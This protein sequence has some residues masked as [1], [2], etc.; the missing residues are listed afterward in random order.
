MK[1]LKRMITV[2]FILTIISSCT[3]FLAQVTKRSDSDFKYDPF[4]HENTDYDVL[5]FG[6]SHVINAIFPMQLW[7]DYGITSYNFGGHANSLAASYWAMVNA[8]QYHKPKIAV[9][10]VLGA[11]QES[12]EMDI[13]YAHLSFDAFPLTNTKLKA[14]KDI[15]PNDSK[16][17]LELIFPYSIYHNKW[18][19]ITA[20]AVKSVVA[21]RD[22]TKEKGAESRI[23]LAIPQEMNLIPKSDMAS[24]SSVGQKYIEMF[25]DYCRTNDIE[26][27]IIN[28]PYPTNEYHQKWSNSVYKLS[29]QSGFSYLNMQYEN[30]VDFDI[31]CHDPS[32]HLNPSGARKITDYLGKYLTA[33][34]NLEDHRLDDLYQSWNEAYQKE[35]RPFL[36][37]K[38]Q[39]QKSFK[40][41]LMLLNNE[42]FSA[43]LFIDKNYMLDDVEEKLID[44]LGE[45]IKVIRVN[46]I[47]TDY[48]DSDNQWNARVVVK[49]KIENRTI[50]DK[51]FQLQ[52][53]YQKA[54]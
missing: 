34:Y 28:I 52:L 30:L 22:H 46:M 12:P 10:D 47:K 40:L 26:P 39:N 9:L 50:A 48:A 25:V 44:Q 6:T 31:D 43:R 53:N 16:K 14:I 24:K 45:N 37:S 35:Y 21:E 36:I 38:I 7:N 17:Q 8:T 42:N 1:H 54:A 29:E 19:S 32:S 3:Y 27:L 20:S 18:E 23:N 11:Y 51:K 5:F 13:S 49:D 15:Y 2:M 41:S 33:H 4:F